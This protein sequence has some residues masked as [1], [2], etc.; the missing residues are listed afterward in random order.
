MQNFSYKL[1][2]DGTYCLMGYQGDEA[3]VVVPDAIGES[4]RITVLYDKVFAGHPEIRS[5]H[6]PDTITDI[7][8]FAFEGCDNLHELRLPSQLVN[9]WGHS[10]A[11]C[12]IIEITLPEKTKHIPP[13]AFK[14]C[15]RLKKVV[16]S[17]GLKKIYPWAFGGCTRLEEVVHSPD[18]EI[19]PRA[20]D[21]K[22]MKNWQK[23]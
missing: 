16:C 23:A 19:D 4:G 15:G 13:F 9:L 1:I 21:S 6:L 5:I 18:T 17:P 10:F 7:G 2:E 8:E 11:R 3:D 14:D 22:Q 20:F 12:G